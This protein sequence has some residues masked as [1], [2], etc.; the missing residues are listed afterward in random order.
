V[1]NWRVPS[2]DECDSLCHSILMDIA[3]KVGRDYDIARP[4]A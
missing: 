4:R 2:L 3:E 1:P